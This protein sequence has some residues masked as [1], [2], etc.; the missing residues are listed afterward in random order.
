LHFN[1]N[2]FGANVNT[3]LTK[4]MSGLVL[5]AFGLIGVAGISHADTL[6]G[7]PEVVV[8][9]GDLDLSHAEGVNVLYHRLADA[10]ARACYLRDGN[11]PERHVLFANCKKAALDDA[12]SRVSSQALSNYYET[13]TLRTAG[14]PQVSR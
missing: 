8:K 5:P 11:T 10:A 14:D 7:M 1:G 2:N 6:D 4:K 3:H 12:V 9:Y 13:R